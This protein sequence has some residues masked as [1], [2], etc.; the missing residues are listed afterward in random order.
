MK[1]V[2]LKANW[3]T[4]RQGQSVGLQDNIALNLIGQGLA[5]DPGVRVLPDAP[6]KV[7][8]KA[9]PVAKKK[10]VAKKPVGRKK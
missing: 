2:I 10:A 6:A 8:A 1:T 4:Y 5:F 3:S 7:I 9:K